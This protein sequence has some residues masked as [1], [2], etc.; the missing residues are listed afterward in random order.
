MDEG[1]AAPE[2]SA[3]VYL[4]LD[5][6]VEDISA[7]ELRTLQ[8]SILKALVGF[9]ADDVIIELFAGSTIVRASRSCVLQHRSP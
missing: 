6:P 7:T 5:K 3:S 4:V 1:N 9:A 8:A 2:G